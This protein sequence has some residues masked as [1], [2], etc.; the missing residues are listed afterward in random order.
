MRGSEEAS[1]RLL[2][3]FREGSPIAD[4]T[5][6]YF[7]NELMYSSERQQIIKRWQG[8]MGQDGNLSIDGLFDDLS[9]LNESE[10]L[11]I[12]QA[13]YLLVIIS[14]AWAYL[15]RN[16]PE[17]LN[18]ELDE[19]LAGRPFVELG[20]S[21]LAPVDCPPGLGLGMGGR[22]K[23]F[24]EILSAAANVDY[25]SCSQDLF[26][27]FY[28][29]LFSAK[30]RHRLGE[31]YTPQWLV[32]HILDT[33]DYGREK[34]ETL[35]D[36]ACGSGAFLIEAWHRKIAVSKDSKQEWPSVVGMDINPLAVLAAKV[37]YLVA[38]RYQWEQ[39]QQLLEIPV[40]LRDIVL[41]QDEGLFSDLSKN[42]ENQKFDFVAGNPPWINWE[43]LSKEYR[44]ATLNVWQRYG[45]FAHSGMDTILGK[46]KKDFSTLMTLV[47]AD[48]YLKPHGKLAFIITQTVFKSGGAA[49]GFRS[50]SLPGGIG[51]KVLLAEDLSDIKP[52]TSAS[53]RTAILYLEKDSLTEYPIPY[54]YWTR[55][56][57][58]G[59]R[60]HEDSF[61]HLIAEPVNRE[62]KRS[63][64]LTYGRGCRDSLSKIIGGSPDYIAREGA[65]TG[66][67]NGILWVE[68]LERPEAGLV[69]I[70][71]LYNSSRRGVSA[72]EWIIEENLVYPLLKGADVTRWKAEPSAHLILTQDPVSRR[73]ISLP[74]MARNYPRTF[75]YL[76]HFEE[77]LSN[78]AAYRRYFK[79]TDPFYSMF[80]VGKY[81]LA[82]IKTVWQRFGRRMK[83][84]V[85]HGETKTVIPQETHT[86]IACKS[87]EEAW[88]LTG[89][90]NSLPIEY[91]V[92]SFSMVG[93]KSF[94]GPNL[95]SSVKIPLYT[96]SSS[97]NRIIEAARQVASGHL[98][99][100]YLAWE[101]AEYYGLT[102]PE[103]NEMKKGWEEIGLE[104][105]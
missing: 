89:I 80:N 95:L 56:P 30:V 49:E 13:F 18:L 72:V 73:G 5:L 88:Y 31:H 35:L 103:F 55:L 84:A 74:I 83:A 104:S 46:G 54:R 82:D 19:L 12:R 105:L 69:K 44:Q 101:V 94:A 25:E 90:L 29:S 1:A 97:Q 7:K 14:V 10:H 96:G 40:Y 32:V 57:E 36:P 3:Y 60:P 64:W 47:S 11:F 39:G 34:G 22:T 81:T 15:N 21:N 76:Q 17:Y 43:S 53:N 48:E 37:N 33:I 102:S 52:F 42:K 66:G 85:V 63:P 79:D 71:N 41:N 67:A 23:I 6:E 92:S 62:D 38:S 86:M 26:Q 68:I 99:D 100:I 20:L 65:N 16:A 24:I 4:Q 28:E 98:P 93:G 70:R 91:A 2:F 87:I 59:S 61:R 27:P 75:K 9:E 8:F 51:L 58:T 77:Q 50:F 78:R 45:L